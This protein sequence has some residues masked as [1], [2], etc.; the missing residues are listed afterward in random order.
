MLPMMRRQEAAAEHRRE[1]QRDKAGDQ[2][3][4]D[5]RDRELVQQPADHAAHETAPE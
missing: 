1:R 5:D 4:N 2:N 3:R